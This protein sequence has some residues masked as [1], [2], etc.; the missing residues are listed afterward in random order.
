LEDAQI[1]YSKDYWAGCN[2]EAMGSKAHGKRESVYYDE[3]DL[4][5]GGSSSDRGGGSSSRRRKKIARVI[6]EECTVIKAK[7]DDAK[8]APASLVADQL[9]DAASRGTK[10]SCYHVC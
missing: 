10:S 2:S 5:S 8:S 3:H 1:A 7:G 6:Y 4:E 9:A